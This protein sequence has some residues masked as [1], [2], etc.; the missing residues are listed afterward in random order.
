MNPFAWIERALAFAAGAAVVLVLSSVYWNGLPWLNDD[1]SISI[2]FVGDVSL[3]DV[4]L[5]GNLVIGHLETERR[6]AAEEARTGLV[7][8][9][10]LDAANARLAFLQRQLDRAQAIRDLADQE[11]KRLQSEIQENADAIS[12]ERAA[13]QGRA[14]GGAVWTDDDVRRVRDYRAARGK[15]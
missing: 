10:E 5:F 3:S 4:P 13:A 11:E 2:P 6:A 15:P 9:L 1:P 8:K 7:S 14:D 12:T